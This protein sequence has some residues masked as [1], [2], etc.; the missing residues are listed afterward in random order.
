MKTIEKKKWIFI[1]LTADRY[2]MLVCRKM[3]QNNTELENSLSIDDFNYLNYLKVFK[4]FKFID[5]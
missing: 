2:I 4:K 5:E 3:T 1:K